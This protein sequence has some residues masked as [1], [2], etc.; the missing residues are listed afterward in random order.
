VL[1]DL[2]K[3]KEVN[4]SLGHLEGDM[5]LARVGRLLEQKCRQSTLSLV[6]VETN[7]SSS[8]LRPVS[9][10]RRFWRKDCASGWRPTDARGTPH[11][12]QFRRCKF[13]RARI[14]HGRPDSRSR[15]R[16][17]RGQA[18]GGNQVSTSDTFGE[19]SAVQ[20]Q[21]VSGYIEGFLQREHNGPEHLEEL[22]S[23]LRKLCEHESQPDQ[24]SDQR[25]DQR[26][27]QRADQRSNQKAGQRAINER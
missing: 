7:L 18:R 10:N 27:E 3:F 16:H 8:C 5:V 19:G 11:H 25:S 20:R 23:T 6:T 4:D 24:R 12:R 26:T 2:D 21:L 13:P 22:I 17:V 15:C 1:I 9:S 14:L